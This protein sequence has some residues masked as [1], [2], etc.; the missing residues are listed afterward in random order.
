VTHIFDFMSLNTVLVAPALSCPHSQTFQP[1]LYQ[2]YVSPSTDMSISYLSSQRT[3]KRLANTSFPFQ[4]VGLLVP[5]AP[6][7]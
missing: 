3:Y 6:R 2:C 4:T 5:S 7:R 1:S